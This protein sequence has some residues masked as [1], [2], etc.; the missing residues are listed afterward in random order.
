MNFF[1]I[2][3]KESEARVQ[4]NNDNE[5][6]LSAEKY[7]LR[8]RERIKKMKEFFRNYQHCIFQCKDT[9]ATPE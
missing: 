2:K 1:E 7:W 3:M 9:Q 4:K 8:V 6:V 5:P